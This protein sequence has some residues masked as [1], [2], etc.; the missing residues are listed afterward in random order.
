M[1][2]HLPSPTSKTSDRQSCTTWTGIFP[3]GWLCPMAPRVP[4]KGCRRNVG[5]AR[6]LLLVWSLPTLLLTWALGTS[7]K[8]REVDQK[9]VC[10][11]LKPGEGTLQKRALFE[12]QHR[13]RSRGDPRWL[14]WGCE[15]CSRALGPHLNGRCSK[16]PPWNPWTANC[17]TLCSR[18]KGVSFTGP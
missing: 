17:H 2:H 16:V 3:L 5:Q 13:R 8:T 10:K 18:L 6:H 9:G 15:V 4:G 12:C 1:R 11:C 7:H 14:I